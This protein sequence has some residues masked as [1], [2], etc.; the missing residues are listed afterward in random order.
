[1]S[2]IWLLLKAYIFVCLVTLFAFIIPIIIGIINACRMRKFRMRNT[3]DL[4][5][6]CFLISFI[7]G[8]GQMTLCKLFTK[9]K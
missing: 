1:M 6:S 4:I 8:F 7:P 5:A 2:I 3:I 9:L